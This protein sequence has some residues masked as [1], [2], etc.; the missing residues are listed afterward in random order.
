MASSRIAAR[1][2]KSLIDLAKQANALDAVKS[3]MDAVVDICA[4]SRELSNLLRNP[5]VSTRDKQA[6]LNS[7]FTQ[8]SPTTLEF[9]SFLVAKKREAELPLVA[10]QFVS[11]YDAMKG[12]ARASVTSA[13]PLSEE[14]MARVKSYVGA[15]IGSTELELTNKVDPTIIGGM[16]VR[17]EDR[18]L[19]M[20]VAKELREIRKELILN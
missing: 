8:C 15:M 1:Y 11:S 9:I 20:S 4:N 16:I 17:H 5:I 6:A 7:I 18:L 14:S 19:D 13:I 10:E 2:S 12:I 3:D